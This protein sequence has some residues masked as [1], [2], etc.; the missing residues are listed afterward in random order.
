M[1]FYHTTPIRFKCT[2]CSQCCYGGKYA[3]VRASAQEIEDITAYMNIDA[4]IFK[5]KYLI[6]LVDHGYG[7]RMKKNSLSGVIKS[8][9]H[10]VL[11]NKQGKCSVY[12]VRPTQCKTYPFWPEILIS[13]DK[14]NNEVMRCEGINQGDVVDTEHVE[15]Q[16]Q[17]TVNA[18]IIIND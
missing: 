1:A 5:N 16:K 7:I 17:L 14:W 4:E 2:Q 15:Q 8:N 11:L 6:K 9:G 10:C 3:Y 18:E 13:K 12:P